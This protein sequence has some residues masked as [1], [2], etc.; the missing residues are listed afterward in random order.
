MMNIEERLERI[1][2]LIAM[3]AKNVLNTKDVAL[4]L[5]V[6]EGRIRHL[7]SDRMIPCYKRGTKNYFIKAEVEKWLTSERV[8]TCEE[9][10]SLASTY[11]ATKR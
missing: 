2:R 1:E 8:E 10:N 5:G 3:S 9:I 11:I 4:M 7:V 6:S